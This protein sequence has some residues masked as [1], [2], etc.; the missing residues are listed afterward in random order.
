MTLHEKSMVIDGLFSVF[1]SANLD[2]RSPEI[3][4]EL[5]VVVYDQNF[6]REME[7]VFEKDLACADEY[8]L[9]QF[10]KRSL[11]ERALSGS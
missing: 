10:H 7:L 9:R 8:T 5:D 6:G 3:N 2:A 4:E 11:W 1:G